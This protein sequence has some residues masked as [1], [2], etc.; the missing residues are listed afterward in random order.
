[1]RSDSFDKNKTLVS[2]FFKY[3]MHRSVKSLTDNFNP[4]RHVDYL[5]TSKVIVNHIFPENDINER[6][7]NMD[8]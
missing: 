2:I 1:M 5:I 3:L 6:C 7:Y 4:S 8:E